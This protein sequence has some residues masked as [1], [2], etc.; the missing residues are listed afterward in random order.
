M[1]IEFR[2]FNL[3]FVIDKFIYHWLIRCTNEQHFLPG[4]AFFPFIKNSAGTVALASLKPD[5]VNITLEWSIGNIGPGQ[6]ARIG[7]ESNGISDQYKC[8]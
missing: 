6:Y 4:P 7:E 2:I 5:P 8:M 3:N 1:N